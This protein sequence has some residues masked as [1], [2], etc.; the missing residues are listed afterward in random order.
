MT[1]DRAIGCF[2]APGCGAGRSGAYP[3][4]L[5]PTPKPAT[6]FFDPDEMILHPNPI[7]GDLL[8]IRYILGESATM[9]LAAFDLSGRMVATTQWQGNPGTAGESHLWSVADLAPG[10]YVIRIEVKGAQEQR[11]L[12]RKVAVVR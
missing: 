6:T 12:M 9:E 7:R 1:N 3:A 8:K 4:N 11:S 5:V 10:V 2:P